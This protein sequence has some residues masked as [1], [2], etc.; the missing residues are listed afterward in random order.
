MIR[1]RTALTYGRRLLRAHGIELTVLAAVVV[2]LSLVVYADA[3]QV[4]EA[5]QGFDWTALFAVVI[6]T[7]VGFCFRFLK[8]EYFLRELGVDI[9][10]STSL[11]V[12]LS[13]LMM[14]ITPMKG[15]GVWKGWLLRDMEE[16]PISRIVPVVVA[17][18]ATDLLALCAL[19]AVGLVAYERSS[20]V[21]IAVVGIF[22]ALTFLLQW[23]RC[24]LAILELCDRVP[25]LS[26]YTDALE[27]TYEGT[28]ELFRPRPLS[29]SLLFSLCAW[30]SEGL[31]IWF[32]LRGF[33]VDVSPLVSLFVFGLGSVVGGVSLLPGGVGA[34]EASI[35]G[36]LRVFGY[37]EAIA[38]GTTV[39]VRVGTL[40][41]GAI[42]GTVV[43]SGFKLWLVHADRVSSRLS[44]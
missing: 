20:I 44:R 8:W 13:G 35:F 2:F 9:P 14:V 38:A 15:G 24:C 30:A 29:V 23:R 39:L 5:L 17:E 43:F 1:P 31:S 41:Y 19:A 42:L 10:I 40:W 16:V 33:G 12:F 22:V 26:Q 11:F 7:T 3:E 25:I 34:A 27:R 37:S 32:I 28:Y 21:V 6:A 4:I 18:R 36:L